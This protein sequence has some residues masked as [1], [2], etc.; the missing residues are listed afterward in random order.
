MVHIVNEV[1]QF[2]GL[3][4]DLKFVSSSPHEMKINPFYMAHNNTNNFISYMTTGVLHKVRLSAI[5][6]LLS[7][8]NILEYREISPPIFITFPQLQQATLSGHNQ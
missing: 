1:T 3:L 6:C 7:F 2:R 5:A 4:T 8:V